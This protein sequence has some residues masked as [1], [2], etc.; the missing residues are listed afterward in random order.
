MTARAG[1]LRSTTALASLAAAA[2]TM[3]ACGAGQGASGGNDGTLK[4]V[5][6]TNVWGS[7]AQAVGGDKV[8]VESIISGSAT[9][10]HS[11]ETTPRDAV[12]VNDADLVLSNG[13]GYDEFLEQILAGSSEP[14]PTVQA[15]PGGHEEHEHGEGGH[16]DGGHPEQ[17]AGQDHGHGGGHEHEHSTNEHVWYDP[18]VVHETAERVADELGKLQPEHAQAFRD[19]A[20]KFSQDVGNLEDRIGQLAE[21]HQGK[22]VIVTEPVAHYLVQQAKLEDIT[23]QSFVK[24][25]ESENDPAAAAIADIQ[26]SVNSKQAAAVVYNPQTESPVTKQVRATAERNGIP[27]VEM[28][29]LLPPGQDYARWMDGQISAL[30]NALTKKP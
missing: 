27:V 21:R 19:S 1:R 23:P 29:E 16:E 30:D 18:H 10:P 28:T 14:K 22:K 2:L 8:E 7:V 9:D 3:S 17:V 26:N 20:G 4:I 11:Y 25:V 24:A 6:S 5:T 12:K 13:G 15:V